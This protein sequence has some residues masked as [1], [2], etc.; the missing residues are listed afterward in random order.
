MSGP[1]YC[2]AWCAVQSRHRLQVFAGV[3]YAQQ[4]QGQVYMMSVAD[5]ATNDLAL[6][7]V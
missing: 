7:Q 3:V 5:S 1:R 2:I 6:T 4:A